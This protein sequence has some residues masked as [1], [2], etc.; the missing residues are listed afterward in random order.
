VWALPCYVGSF[1]LFPGW[2]AVVQPRILA[3][4]QSLG[5]WKG[6]YIIL[7]ISSMAA[8]KATV[9]AV[10]IFLSLAVFGALVEETYFRGYLQPQ[11]S[12]LGRF[13]GVF[14]GLLYGSHDL[15]IPPL[16]PTAMAFGWIHALLFKW[17]KNTWPC[18]VVH[19]IAL[20]VN[21]SVYL[22]GMVK[23]R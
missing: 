15:W 1:V 3:F 14:N 11:M 21:F 4:M 10:L 13:D 5:F 23:A 6:R 9:T 19:F 20:A 8:P 12:S 17:R 2:S 7:E 18:I 22:S 16:I